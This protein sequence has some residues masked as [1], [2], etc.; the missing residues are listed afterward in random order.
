MNNKEL[1][2]LRSS[3]VSNA[4]TSSTSA[5]V[6]SAS[7]AIVRDVEGNE[8]I[9][10]A[11]GIGVM[12]IGHCHPKV[13][14]AVQ[15]QAGKFFHT[16]FMVHP[17]SSAVLLAEKLCKAV[18]GTSDKKAIFLSTGAE[19]VENAVKIA[20]YHT[21]RTGIIVFDNAYH[22][23]TLLTMSMTAKVKPYKYGFGPFAPEIYRA[24]FGDIDA[25]KKLLVTG[26][27][28]ED[29]A[30]VIA[31]P[32]QG[33]GGFIAAP[34]GYFQELAAIC[35]EHG[36]LFVA[37]EIQSGMG[38]TGKMFAIEHWDVEP[39][40]MTVA[41]SLAAGMP[42]SAVVGK[43]EIMDAV[44]GAGLGGT[45]SGNPLACA[46]G[47]AVME[48]FE[49]EE[50]VAKAKILGDKLLER[51]SS[52][53]QKFDCVGEVRGLGAMLGIALTNEDG[54]PAPEKAKA[55][56][57]HCFKNNL[58]ILACGIYGNVIRVLTPFVI[59][60]D[61]L[62]KGFSIMEEGLKTL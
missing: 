57:D 40:L 14:K 38:R 5:Y 11:G 1:Q 26:V 61:T 30:A 16:C 54:T 49:E 59:S 44:H 43:A 2:E 10:F 50:M 58:V 48:I 17:Y 41:K 31:E 46:A 20:R 21:K 12:N 15:E 23:R 28:P 19:A 52:W 33:E 34:E 29:V 56:V 7:G 42:L 39:D 8:Y 18:P 36:I 47:L 13:V 35:K 27:A 62:E 45:Y 9:D 51:F 25:F 24:P 4:H 37:D 55:L 6:E 22:G 32:V 53:Q 60:D 3:Y